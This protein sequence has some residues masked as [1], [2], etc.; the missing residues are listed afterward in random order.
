VVGSIAGNLR[1]VKVHGAVPFPVVRE[2]DD[3]V[4]K[5]S[6][7]QK[8]RTGRDLQLNVV[9]LCHLYDLVKALQP[10]TSRVKIPRPVNPQLVECEVGI[11]RLFQSRFDHVESPDSED[12][13]PELLK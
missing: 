7:P 8:L 2:R 5:K 3:P 11:K 9:F 4:L 12:L 6:Q 10:I 1:V 13:V